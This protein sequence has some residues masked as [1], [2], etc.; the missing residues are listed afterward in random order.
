[1]LSCA[2]GMEAQKG[3]PM[4][5]IRT[6]LTGG[7]LTLAACAGEPTSP[8][9]TTDITASRVTTPNAAAISWSVVGGLDNPRG[10]T[11]GPGGSLY[12]A[13]AGNGGTN[14][15]AGTCTQVPAPTGPY[16]GGPTARISRITPAGQR[17]TFAQGFPSGLD[18]TGGTVGVADVAFLKGKLYALLAG[19]GCSHGNPDVP[20]G[21]VLVNPDGSWQV[22][23]DFSTYYA[24][25][26]VAVP[27]P[28]DLEPDGQPYSME[29]GRKTLHFVEAN[30]GA[31]Y[32]TDPAT[33]RFERT[34]DVSI[35]RAFFSTPTA[36][37]IH[38]HLRYVGNLGHFSL[39]GSEQV[40]RLGPATPDGNPQESEVVARGVNAVVGLA[41][42]RRNRLYVLELNSEAGFFPGSGQILRMGKERHVV[43]SGLEFPTAMTMGPDGAL[44]VSNKGFGFGP[45][46]GEVLRIPL[47]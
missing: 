5:Q 2:C 8:R 17:T 24:A 34:L 44:Y 45:G 47:P 42:D 27:D 37:L 11:F 31:L 10:L 26:P 38:R 3:E 18:G 32:L 21:V 4:S 16:T 9:R 19:G 12:V 33:G 14:S 1:M 46:A 40:W 41:F 35:H 43:A 15:T 39:D 28:T 29:A 23:S 6:L 7:C 25:N 30:G 22:V 36:L 20:N 13:E